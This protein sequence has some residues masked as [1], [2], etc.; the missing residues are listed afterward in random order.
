M[1]RTKDKEK[2]LQMG[3]VE[4]QRI[5]EEILQA[6]NDRRGEEYWYYIYMIET[7]EEGSIYIDLT[8]KSDFASDD[9]NNILRICEENGLVL[10]NFQ[11]DFDE[12][13]GE[14][15]LSLSMSQK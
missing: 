4:A 11:I 9:L 1:I 10:D 13:K 15:I 8:G 7:D 5:A 14:L 12:E 2:T 3:G 6:L